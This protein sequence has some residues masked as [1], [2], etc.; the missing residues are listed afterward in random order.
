MK[1]KEFNFTSSSEIIDFF[2]K[3]KILKDKQN[4]IYF[5]TLNERVI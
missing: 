5:I 3:N 2:I 4:N 1:E